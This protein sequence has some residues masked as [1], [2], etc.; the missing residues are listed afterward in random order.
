MLGPPSRR[1]SLALFKLPPTDIEDVPSLSKGRLFACGLVADAIPMDS[2][3]SIIG[4]RPLMGIVSTWLIVIACPTD[5]VEV[6]SSGASPVTVTASAIAPTSSLM[7]SVTRSLVLSWTPS[8]T[9]R[10]NPGDETATVYVPGGSKGTVY[11]PVADDTVVN[12]EPVEAFVRSMD[13]PG[14]RASCASLTTP[15]RVARNSCAR[16]LEINR[17][18][19]AKARK[20][21][22]RIALLLCGLEIPG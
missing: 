2:C 18:N 4:A 13:A 16:P 19:E 11:C 6:E 9:Y 3:A 1:I 22:V 7:S 10:L 5:A 12:L 8:R 21:K 20:P 17:A 15:F 14:M